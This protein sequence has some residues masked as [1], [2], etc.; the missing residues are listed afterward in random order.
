MLERNVEDA[1]R[2]IQH[3]LAEYYHLFHKPMIVNRSTSVWPSFESLRY[4]LP[5]Y[6]PL[7]SCLYSQPHTGLSCAAFMV[8]GS[9]LIPS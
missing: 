3:F 4:V 5:A 2:M 1:T 8:S 6:L 7:V 9:H